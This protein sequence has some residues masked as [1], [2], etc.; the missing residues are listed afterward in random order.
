MFLVER[1]SPVHPF[2]DAAVARMLRRGREAVG[3]GGRG[4][5]VGAV[6]AGPVG[7]LEKWL[8]RPR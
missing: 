4:G 8:R 7:V 3:G 6:A 1:C 5:G 2:Y